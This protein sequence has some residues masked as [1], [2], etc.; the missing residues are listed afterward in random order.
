MYSRGNGID[1]RG[2]PNQRFRMLK[3]VVVF[4]NQ[5]RLAEEEV[6]SDVSALGV[7]AGVAKK[8]WE[9]T[10]TEHGGLRDL[11]EV[12]TNYLLGRMRNSVHCGIEVARFEHAHGFDRKVPLWE[13]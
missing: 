4:H 13:Y 6:E 12:E 11:T 9:A 7:Q 2:D 5:N 3:D 8:Q 10:I 1:S